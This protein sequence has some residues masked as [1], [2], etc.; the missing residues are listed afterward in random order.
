MSASIL[1]SVSDG[2]S[3]IFDDAV[4]ICENGYRDF[5]NE[6]ASLAR[7]ATAAGRSA[8]RIAGRAIQQAT[9]FVRSNPAQAALETAGVVFMPF[10]LPRAASYMGR[11]LV[12]WASSPQSRNDLHEM[13]RQVERAGI[14]RPLMASPEAVNY[15]WASLQEL[16]G[17]GPRNILFSPGGTEHLN[18]TLHTLYRTNSNPVSFTHT[19]HRVNAAAIGVAHFH[20]VE[21]PSVA[22]ALAARGLLGGGA[23]NNPNRNICAEAAPTENLS[24]SEHANN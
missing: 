23:P 3:Q 15:L 14:G 9:S 22:A 5:Q 13:N 12:Q 10:A 21:S 7:Q 18:P 24:S 11:R 20:R 2:I 8:G 4:T 17:F 19:F 1:R 6:S 16:F